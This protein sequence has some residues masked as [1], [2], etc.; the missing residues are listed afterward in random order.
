MR[1]IEAGSISTNPAAQSG[2]CEC[3]YVYK[4]LERREGD[5]KKRRRGPMLNVV[6]DQRDVKI[7]RQLHLDYPS[8]RLLAPFPPKWKFKGDQEKTKK[9]KR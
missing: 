6:G 2:S 5:D 7:T 9:K 4:E 1:T 3:V 8:A